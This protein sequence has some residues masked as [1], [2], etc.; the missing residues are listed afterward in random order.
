MQDRTYDNESLG[1]VTLRCS[2]HWK[3]SNRDHINGGILLDPVIPSK[4]VWD[5][6]ICI[7]NVARTGNPALAHED[8]ADHIKLIMGDSISQSVEG[9]VQCRRFG[10]DKE[11]VYA[12]LTAAKPDGY[13]YRTEGVRRFGTTIV[14]FNLLSDDENKEILNQLLST[15]QSIAVQKSSK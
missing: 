6:Q 1:R 7:A 8:L 13:R 10:K 11:G 4:L 3:L 14:F 5:I 9:S 12:R 2:R 15:V